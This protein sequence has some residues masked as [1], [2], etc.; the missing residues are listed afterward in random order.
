MRPAGWHH[1]IWRGDHRPERERCWIGRRAISTEMMGTSAGDHRR[2]FEGEPSAFRSLRAGSAEAREPGG[3][4]TGG[5]PTVASNSI[6]RAGTT[7][8]VVRPGTWRISPRTSSNDVFAPKERSFSAPAPPA[9]R[10]TGLLATGR[11]DMNP[12]RS[13][14]G[15]PRVQRRFAGLTLYGDRF[16]KRARRSGPRQPETPRQPTGKEPR[17]D[18]TA[19]CRGF[20]SLTR[21]IRVAFTSVKLKSQIMLP[22]ATHGGG[23]A[24][25]EAVARIRPPNG[26]P[27]CAPARSRN[28]R[29]GLPIRAFTL[30]G[31]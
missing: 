1:R 15:N 12:A 28:L 22:G 20:T 21:N 18:D 27:I 25:R 19:H 31:S 14:A 3:F 6:R 17:G 8:Q 16:T 26:A 5:N 9:G 13:H 4:G 2:G 24:R 10:R 11:D 29:A 23:K 30:D 7:P